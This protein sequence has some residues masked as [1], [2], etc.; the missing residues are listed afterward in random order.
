MDII[1]FNV[2]FVIYYIKILALEQN[3]KLGLCKL[4]VVLHFY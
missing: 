4:S 3:L 2:I 1:Y